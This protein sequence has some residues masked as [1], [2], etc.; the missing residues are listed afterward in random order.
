MLQQRRLL[1]RKKNPKGHETVILKY[2]VITELTLISSSYEDFAF[3]FA[4]KEKP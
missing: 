3:L 4:P 2:L 1:K